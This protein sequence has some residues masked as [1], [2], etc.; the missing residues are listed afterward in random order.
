MKKIIHSSLCAI[1]F[2]LVCVPAVTAGG[3]DD[4]RGGWSE[5][6]TN[7]NNK[8]FTQTLDFEKDKFIFKIIDADKKT[9][10]FAKGE[11]KVE[12][13]LSLNI[14]SFVHIEAGETASDVS[15]VEDDRHCVYFLDDDKLSIAI[16]FDKD[17]QKAPRVEV[18]AKVKK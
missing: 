5:V 18:Y 15:P 1:L 10:L 13:R 6:I 7:E 9:V 17:R 2:G 12:T 4:L 14:V 16:D 3:L 11:V 8:V